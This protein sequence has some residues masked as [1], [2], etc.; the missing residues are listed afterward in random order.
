MLYSLKPRF[1]AFFT[2]ALLGTGLLSIAHADDHDHRRPNSIHVSGMGRISIAPD[3]AELTLSVEVQAKSAEA[4]RNQ[5]ATAMAALI[6]AVKNADV[7]DKDIQTRYVSLYPIYT[8]DTANKISG[9]QLA[10]QVTV[11]VRD[12]GKISSVIDSAV[13]AGGNAVRVQGVSFAID[14][15]ESALSQAREKA[16]ADA[17]SKAEQY[18]KLAD[19]RLGRAIQI[20]EGGGMPPMPVPFAEMSAMKL[21]GRAADSTPV[22]VGEQEVSVTVEVVFGVE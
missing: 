7:A 20:S 21:G 16:Y 17:L 22:Q 3:K 10:N 4:A 8:P 19:I 11:I 15:P 2:L 13:N 1:A 18:A 14:N 12:I 6:K 5:A 9:Y